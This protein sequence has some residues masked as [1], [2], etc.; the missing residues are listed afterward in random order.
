MSRA[1][2]IVGALGTGGNRPGARTA[3]GPVFRAIK[4]GAWRVVLALTT[5]PLV[6]L[7]GLGGRGVRRWT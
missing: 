1:H 2:Q 3:H 6:M 4:Q 5:D 7:C